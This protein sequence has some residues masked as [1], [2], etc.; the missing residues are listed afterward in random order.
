LN[1]FRE[2][3]NDGPATGSAVVDLAPSEVIRF[4]VPTLTPHASEVIS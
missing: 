2:D 1:D 4:T 3:V